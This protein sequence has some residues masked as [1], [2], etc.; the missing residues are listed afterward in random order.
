MSREQR[1]EVSV[2]MSVHNAAPSLE[3]TLDSVLHQQGVELEF[4]VVNDGSNDESA[5]I[6]DVRAQ[7]DERLIVLHQENT[8]LTVALRRGCER[9]RGRYIARQDAGGDLSLPGRLVR[10]RDVLAA[11]PEAVMVSCGTRFVGPDG[12]LLFEVAQTSHELKAGLS[13]LAIPGIRG[14]SHHG[15]TMFRGDAYEH[16][17]GYRPEYLVAQDM[18]LWLRLFELGPC[19]AVND[20]LYQARIE[21]GSI[22]SRLQGRQVAFGRAAIEAARERRLGRPEPPFPLAGTVWRQID[23]SVDPHEV[24]NM[25]YFLGSCLLTV[26]RRRAREHFLLALKR[27]PLHVRA[28]ARALRSLIPV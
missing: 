15:S 2:V 14:P 27:H 21:P 11:N 22:T 8:G 4:V 28:W 7:H 16:A 19:L 5:A 25:H 3:A 18:D 1:P 23:K 9:A 12:E 13:T 26:D 20:L 17:G 10:Q 6:L 24:A